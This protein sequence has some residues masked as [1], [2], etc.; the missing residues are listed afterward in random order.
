MPKLDADDRRY[1]TQLREA[2]VLKDDDGH[3][4]NTP[5]GVIM[6]ACSD[7]DQM[8]DVYEHT[9]HL[10]ESNSG[11]KRRVHTLMNHG[12]AML[13]SP[14]NLLYV[15]RAPDEFLI[16]QIAKARKTNGVNT[17]VLVVH[18]PCGAA[19]MAELSVVEVIDHMFRG[20]KQL[21]EYWPELKVACFIHVDFGNKKRMYFVK[22]KEWGIWYTQ[23]ETEELD[24]LDHEM[25]AL[26]DLDPDAAREVLRCRTDDADIAATTPDPDEAPDISSLETDRLIRSMHKSGQH[27]AVTPADLR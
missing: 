9:C 17:V 21:K 8:G 27:L 24:R 6:V 22:R 23:W 4:L 10:A 13:L 1:V 15:D 16:Q 12:G 26:A 7:G 14:R 11:K 3:K 25:E 20:K 18:A 2:G 5:Q 19:E